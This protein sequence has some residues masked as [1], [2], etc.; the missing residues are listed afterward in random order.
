MKTEN[1]DLR[2]KLKREKKT[3]RR[4]QNAAQR[5]S[6]QLDRIAQLDGKLW[7]NSPNGHSVQF[8]PLTMPGG[9]HLHREP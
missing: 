4:V 5:Y 3:R 9:D 6:E 1:L 2:V 7:L 8:L